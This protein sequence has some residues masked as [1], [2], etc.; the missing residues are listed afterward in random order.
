MDTDLVT[1]IIPLYNCEDQIKRCID[2]ILAQTYKNIE[3]VV[4]D[5]GSTDN[6]YDVVANM[7]DPRI[8][9]Y[10]QENHGVSYTRN[11]GMDLAKGEWLTFVDSDDYIEP[12]M[13]ERMLS[14]P[15]INE[16]NIV[17]CGVDRVSSDGKIVIYNSNTEEEKLLSPIS[18][19]KLLIL[20]IASNTKS[21]GVFLSYSACKIYRTAFLNMNRLRFD[22][23]LSFA[24]D[25]FFFIACVNCCNS[26]YVIHKPLYHYVM[27]DGSLSKPETDSD[28]A[29][30]T[31]STL[32]SWEMLFPII[33]K[34]NDE[35]GQQFACMVSHDFNRFLNRSAKLHINSQRIKEISLQISSHKDIIDFACK[36]G[37]DSFMD[38]LSLTILRCRS[39]WLNNLVIKGFRL[40]CRY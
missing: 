7:N 32:L 20:G 26:V 25:Q 31:T 35:L 16:L 18:A 21:N 37:A 3:V 12:D 34:N 17:S 13:I 36:Q 10:T 9:L 8:R 22:T 27:R 5:D 6:S 2:S 14:V 40:F 19:I 4:I 11:K 39:P 28:L 29:R 24:E 38:K 15:G 30:F 33:Y 1:V 23:T